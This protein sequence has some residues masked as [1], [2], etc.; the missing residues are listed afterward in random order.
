MICSGIFSGERVSVADVFFSPSSGTFTAESISVD[1]LVYTKEI[2]VNNAEKTVEKE[3]EDTEK[4][5]K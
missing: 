1:V 4:E 3:I 5:V 2:S